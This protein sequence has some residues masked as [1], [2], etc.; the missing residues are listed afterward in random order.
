MRDGSIGP[1][2]AEN[3]PNATLR[4]KLENEF[5]SEL[6]LPLRNRGPDKNSREAAEIPCSVEDVCIAVAHLRRREVRMI[7]DV[8]HLHAKLY[9][10]VL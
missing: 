3:F 7:Q 9:V 6:N 2:P 4:Q 5:E 1:G 8:K 10:E